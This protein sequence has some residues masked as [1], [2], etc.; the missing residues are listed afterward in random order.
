MF[1]LAPYSRRFAPAVGHRTIGDVDDLFDRLLWGSDTSGTRGF[2]DFDLYEKDGSLYFSM[3]AP[4]VNPEDLDVVIRKESISIRSKGETKKGDGAEQEDGRT[5][6]SKKSV[7]VF[8]Y[9]VSLPFGV[10][11]ERAEASFENG[12]IHISA[13]RLQTAESKL[14]QLKRS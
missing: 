10:D 9:E 11:T 14:L 4:G 3:E 6:Y 1:A 8:N 2:R 13:P 7:H 12:V 5:W